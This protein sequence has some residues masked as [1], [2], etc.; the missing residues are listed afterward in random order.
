M[1]QSTKT[2]KVRTNVR[3]GTGDC[4]E[5]DTNCHGYNVGGYKVFDSCQNGYAFAGWDCIDKVTRD[6]AYN[7]QGQRLTGS[8]YKC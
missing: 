6:S 7:G 5:W 4:H 2:F 3:A 8:C 1:Q